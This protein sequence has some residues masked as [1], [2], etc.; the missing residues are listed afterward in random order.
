[1]EH[2]CKICG[3]QIYMY[4]NYYDG[5]CQECFDKQLGKAEKVE[6]KNIVVCQECYEENFEGAKICSNCGAQLYYNDDQEDEKIEEDEQNE[7]EKQEIIENAII[8]KKLNE[9]SEKKLSNSN[10]VLGKLERIEKLSKLKEKEIITQKE[11]EDIKKKIL[12][13]L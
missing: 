12:N 1:M 5:I 11:F 10:S 6:R 8:I 9:N 2:Y 4:E 3:R 7:N 13:T